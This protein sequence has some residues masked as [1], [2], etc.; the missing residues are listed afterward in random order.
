MRQLKA[1]C[2]NDPRSMK[3]FKIKK[4]EMK[5]LAVGYGACIAS[6]MITVEGKKVWYMYR[7]KPIN[8]TDNGW[9]FLSGYENEEYMANPNNH[10]FYDTNTIAN[11]DPDIINFI[12]LPHGT[13]C[14]RNDNGVLVII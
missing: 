12:D 5:P 6:D 3:K 9:R 13:Q 8:E 11:Y 14:E 2:V 4:E 10:A 1:L 7:E